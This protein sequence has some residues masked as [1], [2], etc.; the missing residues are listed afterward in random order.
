MPPK[1]EKTDSNPKGGG[2]KDRRA[3]AVEMALKNIRKA[4]GE[5]CIFD[6]NTPRIGVEFYPTGCHPLD[7]ILGGGLARGRVSEVF[8]PESAGKSSVSLLSIAATQKNG[9]KCALIDA[10]HAFNPSYA[11]DANVNVD[12]MLLSQPDSGDDALNIVNILSKSGGVDLIVV[13]SVAALVPKAELEGEIGDAT[14]GLQARLMSEF[15][16]KTIA[17]INRT[18]THVMFV[19]QTR[20]NISTFGYGPKN[21]TP[22]GN[23][24]KFYASQRLEVRRMGYIKQGEE[25]IGNKVKVTCVK[26]KIWR[27]YKVA[28]LSLLFGKG[29]DPVSSLVGLAALEG[30][31]EKKGSW[32]S[33]DGTTIGQGELGA[34]RTLEGNP[35]LL[36]TIETSLKEK[37]KK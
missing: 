10:E 11:L 9:G 32:F 14:I 33:Y 8:G 5:G 17:A 2:P 35:E 26:N 24:L 31:I 21:V 16:R 36:Q 23:S 6:K 30:I 1:K 37:L 22:G 13:D 28:E 25:V 18:D 27:P 34:V 19:N 3:M 7:Y 15:F 12:D 4:Y 20:S 29:I